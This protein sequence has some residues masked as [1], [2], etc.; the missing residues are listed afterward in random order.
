MSLSA[1][2]LRPAFSASM[3]PGDASHCAVSLSTSSSE[4]TTVGPGVFWL[5][6]SFVPDTLSREFN[7]GLDAEL[8][9]DV[10]SGTEDEEDGTG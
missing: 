9:E 10:N 1:L 7:G 2:E 4:S 5:N 3:V 6:D 8:D